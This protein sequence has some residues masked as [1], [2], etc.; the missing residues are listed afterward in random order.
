M[1]SKSE[2]LKGLIEGKLGNLIDS[3]SIELGD[4]C[5]KIKSSTV[6]DFFRILK[7]DSELYFEMLLSITAIDWLDSRENRFEVVYHLLSLKNGHRIRVRSEVKEGAEELPSITGLWHSANFMEREC[8]D[9]YGIKFTGHPDLRRILMYEEFVGYP[10]RKDYP[11]Q[12]KQPRIQML[13][14]EARNT[15]MDMQRGS[16]GLVNIN[17][18]KSGNVGDRL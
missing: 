10:L 11:V 15:A 9:M 3:C 16:L 2:A 1:K 5:I 12:G 13:H 14:P 18:R 8:F 7:M 4:V 6:F 17:P